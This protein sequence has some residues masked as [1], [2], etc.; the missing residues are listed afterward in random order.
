[1]VH[2]PPPCKQTKNKCG[3]HT[4]THSSKL[5][6]QYCFYLQDGLI[7]VNV[8]KIY[9]SHF[10][11]YEISFYLQYKYNFWNTLYL[12]DTFVP[13]RYYCI[14]NTFL[15]IQDIG[16][17]N[18]CIYKILLYLQYIPVVFKYFIGKRYFCIHKMRLFLQYKCRRYFCIS[19]ILLYLQDTFELFQF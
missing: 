8:T 10:C 3:Q 9:I 13:A 6:G 12:Q 19:K 5:Q 16:K 17:I 7:T 11:I 2:P 14:F 4:H 18:F 15:Q 1:M